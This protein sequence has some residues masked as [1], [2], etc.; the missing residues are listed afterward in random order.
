LLRE[1][2][3]KNMGNKHSKQI[4]CSCGR[5]GTFKAVKLSHTHLIFENLH[6]PKSFKFGTSEMKSVHLIIDEVSFIL[7]LKK[8]EPQGPKTS[9]EVFRDHFPPGSRNRHAFWPSDRG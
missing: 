1:D 4:I 8:T 5:G 2:G 3:K 7:K 6:V 9:R